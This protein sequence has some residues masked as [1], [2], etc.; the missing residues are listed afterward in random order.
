MITDYLYT[1]GKSLSPSQREDVLK[2]VEVH[3]YDYLEENFGEKKY[4]ESEI[5]QAM[6]SMGHPRIVAEAYSNSPRSLIAPSY[7]DTYWLVIKITLIGTAISLTI[8]NLFFIS[9]AKD[10]IQFFI[11]ILS[12]IW[13]SSL[14]IIGFITLLFAAINYYSPQRSTI[15]DNDWSVKT[16][17]K[18][19]RPKDNIKVFD[20]IVETFFICLGLV[21]INQITPVFTIND[22][23][24]PIIKME[25]LS[26]YIIWINVI[27]GA[28]L[29]LNMYLLIKGQWQTQTRVITMALDISGLILFAKI[30]F[31]PEIWDF[32]IVNETLKIHAAFNWLHSSLYITLAVV[33]CIIL[34]ETYGHLKT[35]VTSKKN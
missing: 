33:A 30:V 17:E 7:I 14:S 34:F 6:K 29:L 1:I 5:E 18:K 2:E 13:Q 20:L 4:T 15:K 25:Y 32:S 12:Q 3:L 22:T 9:E 10:G 26:P 23:S 28:S 19:P 35:I 8:A 31:T 27:L 11:K 16:L 24:I 21:V